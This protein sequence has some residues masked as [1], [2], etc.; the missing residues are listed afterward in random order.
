MIGWPALGLGAATLATLLR[1]RSHDRRAHR[2]YPPEG[3]V[4]EVDKVPIHAVQMGKGP[5]LVF[6]HG[7]SGN[8]R[9]VTLELLPRLA[10]R[11]RVI[12]FDRPGLGHSG[13]LPGH[14]GV[15]DRS[16]ESPAD[17]AAWLRKAAAQLGAER[18]ILVGQSYGGAVALAW[19]LEHPHAVSAL[20]SLAGV[21]MPWPGKLGLRTRVTGTALGGAL[22]PPVLAA[23]LPDRIVSRAIADIFAPQSPPPGYMAHIGAP[24]TLR[25]A[26]F[27][28][29]ARQ[30]NSLRPHI[31]AMLPRYASL[32]LPVEIIHGDADTTVPLSVH[33]EPLSR[34]VPGARLT[35]LPGIGHMPH[36]AAPDA[37]EAA[38]DRAATRAGLR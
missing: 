29:N 28:A 24:L 16:G 19:A 38:I 6:I 5:D 7:A 33:S 18:P 27:R 1:A 14:G 10:G 34:L 3:R 21:A 9:D 37:V 12:A 32:D 17:Q 15:F 35:V 36:H 20:V 8:T 22:L 25:A 23:W 13:R 31:V 11:Y 26:A 30:V 2:A 4:L